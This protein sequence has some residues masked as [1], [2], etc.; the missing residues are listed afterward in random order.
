MSFLKNIFTN[1]RGIAAAR[2]IHLAECALPTLSDD[3]KRKVKNQLIEMWLQST[4]GRIE[5]HVESFN[6]YDRITQ[7]NYL[8]MA[9][10]YA[11]LESPVRDENWSQV[12]R[13]GIY[14]PDDKDMA[15]NANYFKQKYGVS[16]S[17][18]P[19]TINISGW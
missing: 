13:P 8:A 15:V 3:D 5:D 14:L 6:S 1:G 11:G 2:N 12:T 16:V 10:Y 18:K 4:G 9:M 17:V 7:L 19:G